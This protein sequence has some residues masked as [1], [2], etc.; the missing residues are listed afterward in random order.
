MG[1]QQWAL[2]SG[3]HRETARLHVL[4]GEQGIK[5]RQTASPEAQQFQLIFGGDGHRKKRQTVLQ[6]AQC[7]EFTCSWE[8]SKDV[9]LAS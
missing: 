7:W 6:E 5:K 1:Y 2:R 9:G 4:N 8:K 3:E